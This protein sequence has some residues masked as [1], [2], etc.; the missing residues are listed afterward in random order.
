MK[1]TKSK[2]DAITTIMGETIPAEELA[3][4]A[5]HLRQF[6]M[7]IEKLKRDPENA[8]RHGDEDL[9]TTAN[10]LKEFGQ[11]HLIH[12]DPKTG[13][14]KVGNGRHEAASAVLGWKYIAA[15]P[16]DLPAD[17]LRAF[18]LA[19]NRTAEKSTWDQDAL[20]REL[21]ALGDGEIDM[22]GL[23]FSADDIDEIESGF[24]DLD[25][26]SSETIPMKRKS[27]GGGTTKASGNESSEDDGGQAG[28]GE[29]AA[30]F[31]VVITCASEAEQRNLLD[32]FNAEGLRV[33]A[34][35]G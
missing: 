30:T 23:G 9:A 25:D 35:Q 18:A 5:P 31:R 17:K 33:R 13:I 3:Y 14:V 22:S 4:I 2:T 26:S 28:G 19:D 16:S 20:Q 11:Q 27:R 15:I 1:K 24:E 6:A 34:V 21:D 32:R 10:S 7:A 8:R 29:S 12:F